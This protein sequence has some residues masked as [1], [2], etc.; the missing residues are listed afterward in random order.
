M[1]RDLSFTWHF[2]H[3]PE[4]VWECITSPDILEEWLMKNDFRPVVGHVFNF[5]AKPIPQM[6]FDGIIYCEVLE[7][8]PLKK[9]VYT[10]KGGPGPGVIT[11]DTTLTW[12]LQPQDGGTTLLLEQKGFKGFKNYLSSIF[13]GSGWNG[14]IKKRLINVLNNLTHGSIPGNR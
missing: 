2:P 8:V 10:W 12:T 4:A 9:L 7:V 1:N 6:N 3:S 13:M 14:R 11:L 5:H